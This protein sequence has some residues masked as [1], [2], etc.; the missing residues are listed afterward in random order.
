MALV[1]PHIDGQGVLQGVR[2]SS[3]WSCWWLQVGYDPGI[4]LLQQHVFPNGEE[5][6]QFAVEK[7][8]FHQEDLK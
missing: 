7:P 2:F 4:A 3:S 1:I 5:F 8:D 6:L